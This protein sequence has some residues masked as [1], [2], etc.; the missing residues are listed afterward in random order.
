MP[1]FTGNRPYF[2]P[3]PAGFGLGLPN[4]KCLGALRGTSGR[5][6]VVLPPAQLKRAP[7]LKAVDGIG[8]PS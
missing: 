6:D 3:M 2:T 7:I 8:G 1:H 5:G 4:N